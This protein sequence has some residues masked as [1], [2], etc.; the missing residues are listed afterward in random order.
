MNLVASSVF[1]KLCKLPYQVAIEIK[2]SYPR[3]S[4]CSIYFLLVKSQV[5]GSLPPPSSFL[6]AC[7]SQGSIISTKYRSTL[8]VR[9]SISPRNYSGKLVRRSMFARSWNDALGIRYR[10]GHFR[11]S[12][13]N[14]E[15]IPSQNDKRNETILLKYWSRLIV[16][17][18][19][20]G[21]TIL[22]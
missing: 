18:I 15:M 12:R 21:N 22:V 17:L 13:G 11:L 1:F 10:R 2:P 7:K 9:W 19:L 8:M 3:L 6:V 14:E 16:T 4:F 20:D 5:K